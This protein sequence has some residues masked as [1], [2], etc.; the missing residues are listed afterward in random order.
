ML[1]LILLLLHLIPNASA[2]A[3]LH[4]DPMEYLERDLAQSV[5]PCDDFYEYTCRDFGKTPQPQ[6]HS[7]GHVG[8]VKQDLM[9]VIQGAVKKGAGGMNESL[10]KM[11]VSQIKQCLRDVFQDPTD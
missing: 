5:D 9:K 1:L 6:G 3:P 10:V 7:H 2:L 11:Y 8:G 4:L